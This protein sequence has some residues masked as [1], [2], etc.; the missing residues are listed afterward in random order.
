MIK[1]I[2]IGLSYVVIIGLGIFGTLHFKNKNDNQVAA[3]TQLNSQMTAVQM[4]LDSIGSLATV[5]EVI[6]P[7]EDT[8]TFVEGDLKEVS[9]PMSALGDSSITD[10][11]Q[12]IG[13]KSMIDMQTGTIITK[14]MLMKPDDEKFKY[15]K[16]ITLP[17]L[18]IRLQ[19][20][21]YIDIY[22]S[23]L[24]GEL[25]PI[26]TH[27]EVQYIDD[28][29]ITLKISMEEM[30]CWD[31]AMKDYAL[32]NEY[33]F[34]IFPTR[35]IYPGIDT[36]VAYYPVHEDTE[37]MVK[38]DINVNDYTRCVN[39]TLR[40]HIDLVNALGTT[41]TN[42]NLSPIISEFNK[43]EADKLNDLRE[44]R[45]EEEAEAAEAA[46]EDALVN[47]DPNAMT[48]DVVGDVNSAVG[49]AM[50]DLENN[51]EDLSTIE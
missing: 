19:A 42:Q 24:N 13:Q 12:I 4:Q 33:G 50:V 11:S 30:Y 18:P 29:T 3:N 49:D 14:D 46:E 51:F 22:A 9:I 35:Y 25:I 26:L 27:K 28:L 47:S 10:K 21:E 31:A 1:K 34:T 8:H 23:L 5:Y 44:E 38:F 43:A 20:G 45:L 37:N 2:L 7:I 36:T 16:E 48:G 39:T 40:Q 17:Y 15:W 41:D 6:T 32:F